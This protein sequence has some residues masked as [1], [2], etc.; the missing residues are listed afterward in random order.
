MVPFNSNATTKSQHRSDALSLGKQPL[1]LRR[2]PAPRMKEVFSIGTQDLD[3]SPQK[4]SHTSSAQISNISQ[5]NTSDGDK[6]SKKCSSSTIKQMLA[7]NTITPQSIF[8]SL[9]L[10]K[11]LTNLVS[12]V[13]DLKSKKKELLK[14]YLRVQTHLN[15][16]NGNYGAVSG[17]PDM[18]TL[19]PNLI[20]VDASDNKLGI[21]HFVK[22]NCTVLRLSSNLITDDVIERSLELHGL[23]SQTPEKLDKAYL[24]KTLR[25]LDL[26]NNLIENFYTLCALLSKFFMLQTV[27][28]SN[29]TLQIPISTMQGEQ[30]TIDK[31][32]KLKHPVR[33]IP[34]HTNRGYI[35]S[36]SGATDQFSHS[37]HANIPV[38]KSIITLVM[39]GI[40]MNPSFFSAIAK[41][42]PNLERLSVRGC[43]ITHS[44]LSSFLDFLTI[45]ELDL[46]DNP[47]ISSIEYL[48]S[49]A[50]HT[51]SKNLTTIWAHNSIGTVSTKDGPVHF[52]WLDFDG[53]LIN[54]SRNPYFQPDNTFKTIEISMFP[55]SGIKQTLRTG[56][57]APIRIDTSLP[58][59][60]NSSKL[61]SISV[62][63]SDINDVASSLRQLTDDIDAMEHTDLDKFNQKN[64]IN[65]SV[66]DT[67]NTAME[68]LKIVSDE[69]T[70]SS[71]R[72]FNNDLKSKGGSQSSKSVISTSK[73]LSSYL[74]T[75]ADVMNLPSH[76]RTNSQQSYSSHGSASTGKDSRISSKTR[77]S[78]ASKS[79]LSIAAILGGI[80]APATSIVAAP[81]LGLSVPSTSNN[82]SEDVARFGLTPVPFSATTDRTHRLSKN[83]SP[84]T[85]SPP[86]SPPYKRPDSTRRNLILGTGKTVVD[87]YLATAR[88]KYASNS[89]ITKAF[90]SIKS[91]VD[92]QP[93]TY[94]VP[95]CGRL[96]SIITGNTSENIS[97]SSTFTQGSMHTPERNTLSKKSV[98]ICNGGESPLITYK[99]QLQ[100]EDRATF[101]TS[102]TATYS[103]HDRAVSKGGTVQDMD[104]ADE[105]LT[106]ELVSSFVHAS[107]CGPLNKSAP[108]SLYT[109][110]LSFI[111]D[112]SDISDP[113]DIESLDDVGK[114]VLAIQHE[115]FVAAH[116]IQPMN[117][118]KATDILRA[119]SAPP[120]HS[121]SV[122]IVNL[123]KVKDSVH[124]PVASFIGGNT[125]LTGTD[126]IQEISDIEE[127][128]HV[129]TI[130]QPGL[131]DDTVLTRRVREGIELIT[132]PVDVMGIMQSDSPLEQDILSFLPR[133]R[134]SSLR[135]LYT[136]LRMVLEN[137][138]TTYATITDEEIL[139]SLLQQVN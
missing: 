84:N 125:F 12:T 122:A 61:Q 101:D 120:R 2:K 25:V 129:G 24:F 85:K 57:I 89:I 38:V 133:G 15:V 137:P 68:Q 71:S 91:F 36:L 81:T 106:A 6:L 70:Q 53:N 56:A 27:I 139:T 128:Q 86:R 116:S 49:C 21:H 23:L 124:P 39:D 42:F 9:D 117:G 76:T 52:L 80:G 67:I 18:Q 136:A 135:D 119:Q 47:G 3:I 82:I 88:E 45:V 126:Y 59:I 72:S 102:F 46:S 4:R 29:N 55:N 104:L 35:L 17:F 20:E 123:E 112:V 100:S 16:S 50:L 60:S 28:L 108:A 93:N 63:A 5:K 64:T 98:D 74:I 54:E 62:S 131:F 114:S 7:Q 83:L 107:I 19:M 118:K 109:Q 43:S 26:S 115:R 10:S 30:L 99:L 130:Q 48:K 37:G 78:G 33:N 8:D 58:K 13:D 95:Y 34:P 75:T 22:F 87:E 92:I 1:N 103:I 69:A 127:E 31:Y 110:R 132:G 138:I 40:P 51:K 65:E 79:S 134:R 73:S 121:V 113:S 41:A 111:D 97:S 77:S 94:S 105:T 44:F 14:N 11:Q 90:A 66:L 32:L 96:S